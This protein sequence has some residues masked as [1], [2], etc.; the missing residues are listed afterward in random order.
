MS[1]ARNGE[2]L[3]L[4]GK[5]ITCEEKTSIDSGN[6]RFFG[7]KLLDKKRFD[8]IVV[9]LPTGDFIDRYQTKMRNLEEMHKLLNRIKQDR[10]EGIYLHFARY[11][12]A[13][14]KKDGRELIL[15]TRKRLFKKD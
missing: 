2:E 15:P 14:V 1:T 13:W 12:S 7:V 8:L 4:N 6:F 5:L 3:Q 9:S 10:D 11:S